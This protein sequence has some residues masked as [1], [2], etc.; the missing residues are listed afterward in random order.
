MIQLLTLL[1]QVR[2][3]N[4][5]RSKESVNTCQAA[6]KDNIVGYRN[7][8]GDKEGNN[9]EKVG[10]ISA[11]ERKSYTDENAAD[12]S[13]YVTAIDAYGQESKPS[14]IAEGK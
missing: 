10:S 14:E 1:F 9:F 7:Y 8:R 5:L 4:L 13:Y 2:C 12:Y 11:H 6:T 3:S